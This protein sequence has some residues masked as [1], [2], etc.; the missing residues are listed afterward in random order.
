[1]L[2]FLGGAEGPGVGFVAVLAVSIAMASL[3][4]LVGRAT[5]VANDGEWQ[6]LAWLSGSAALGL[7]FLLAIA[8]RGVLAPYATVGWGAGAILL[9]VAGLFVRLRP[10]RLLGL[11]GL[12][13]C[14][15]R[16][17]LVDL[18]SAFHRIIAFVVLGAVLLWVGFSYHR[19]RHLIV[20]TKEKP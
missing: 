4:W 1:V 10:Y 9:F 6:K 20:D 8:Q 3:P 18:Q 13:V 11:A 5:P 12:L 17:F 14:I 16:V 19:F 2:A 7:T 15:P